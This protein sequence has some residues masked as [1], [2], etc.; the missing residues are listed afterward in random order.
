ML[1]SVVSH[2]WQ[3]ASETHELEECEGFPKFIEFIVEAN[4]VVKQSQG[5]HS[6]GLF[7]VRY[8]DL[9]KEPL[10]AD[11]LQQLGKILQRRLLV[12][13]EIN[14]QLWA[15]IGSLARDLEDKSRLT[16][17]KTV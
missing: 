16:Y 8:F 10:V 9:R 13:T 5:S 6:S 2:V 15:R 11:I 1:F 17:N 4:L 7:R 14:Q 12:T 3:D